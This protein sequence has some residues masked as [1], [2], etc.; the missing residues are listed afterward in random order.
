MYVAQMYFWHSTVCNDYHFNLELLLICLK[1]IIL[2]FRRTAHN[3]FRKRNY[4]S[5]FNE[6]FCSSAVM[7]I[8]IMWG[9]T[10]V[11][12]LLLPPKLVDEFFRLLN[13]YCL[14]VHLN[15][16]SFWFGCKQSSTEGNGDLSI[17]IH[18]LSGWYNN[19]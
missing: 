10:T 18:I 9:S 12:F 17:P 4:L 15:W 1:V 2:W 7:T 11:N 5:L 6:N 3:P 14:S 19:A 13:I 16:E 8:F